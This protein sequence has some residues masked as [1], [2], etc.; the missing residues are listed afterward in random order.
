MIDKKHE[1][2]LE[3]RQLIRDERKRTQLLEEAEAKAKLEAKKDAKD[4]ASK[5]YKDGNLQT[6]NIP[7]EVQRLF[8]EIGISTKEGFDKNIKEY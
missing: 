6:D 1:N 7:P 5:Y 3:I 2:S 4:I 8:A